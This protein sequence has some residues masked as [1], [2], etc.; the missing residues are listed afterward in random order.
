MNHKLMRLENAVQQH[1]DDNHTP[2]VPYDVH[3]HLRP[4]NEESMALPATPTSERRNEYAAQQVNDLPVTG[5]GHQSHIAPIFQRASGQ[6]V[7]HSALQDAQARATELAEQKD[8]HS[9]SLEEDPN[10]DRR[11]RQRKEKLNSHQPL[12]S[13]PF[14]ASKLPSQAQTTSSTQLE[15]VSNPKIA[16]QAGNDVRVNLG[17]TG[18]E[19]NAK[20]YMPYALHPSSILNTTSPIALVDTESS[21]ERQNITM[22]STLTPATESETQVQKTG[23]TAQKKTLKL[24]ANGK[25]TSPSKT[26]TS[27]TSNSQTRGRKTALKKKNANLSRVVILRYSKDDGSFTASK[28]VEILAGGKKREV[29]S[30]E[31]VVK[32]E[33]VSKVTHPFFANKSKTSSGP[34]ADANETAKTQKDSAESPRPKKMTSTPT[35][36]SRFADPFLVTGG[37]RGATFS[38]NPDVLRPIWPPKD[39]GGQRMPSSSDKHPGDR[40]ETLHNRKSKQAILDLPDE[41]SILRQIPAHKPIAPS[42]AA[43]P[44]MISLPSRKIMGG[45]EC[46][47]MIDSDHSF[48]GNGSNQRPTH[49]PIS[50]LRRQTIQTRPAFDRG[51]FDVLPWTTKHAPLSAQEVLQRGNEPVFLRNW[52]QSLT[53]S[54]VESG[55]GRARPREMGKAKRKKKRPKKSGDELD[56]FIVS[57]DDEANALNVIE[58]SEDELSLTAGQNYKR[59]AFRN[60]GSRQGSHEVPKNA[61]LLSG[62]HGCGKTAAVYAVSKELGFEVFEIN[63]GSR[64]GA[65]D[66]LDK[67]GDMTQNHLVQQGNSSQ[68]LPDE[69]LAVDE[70]SVQEEVASGRQATMGTFFKS[71]PASTVPSTLR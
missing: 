57:T 24:S 58:Y 33:K 31:A 43:P 1:I 36:P 4:E 64:R 35:R 10:R 56:D 41:E 28:I 68:G 12:A 25:L 16:D 7:A 63:A 65:K 59:S 61:I 67:V 13:D 30:L 23:R 48:L 22:N 62:P 54:A 29:A 70:A 3:H 50:R 44:G 45:P 27:P 49:P 6:R 32:K 39:F 55:A 2:S 40:I 69:Q 47:N 53:I 38:K 21:E 15:G 26:E 46:L 66:I 11:K 17:E 19:S 37:H 60:V 9:A 14:S 34:N 52:I 71:K 20:S 42:G 51:T 5:S 18:S 8:D